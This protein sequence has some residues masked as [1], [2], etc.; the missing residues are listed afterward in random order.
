MQQTLILEADEVNHGT[1]NEMPT[2]EI[3]DKLITGIS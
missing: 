2:F 1:S 3:E